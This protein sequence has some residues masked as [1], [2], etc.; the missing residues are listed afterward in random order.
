MAAITTSN[1]TVL[2]AARIGDIGNKYIMV[3]KRLKITLSA[4]GGTAADIP[5]SVLGFTLI[6]GA[7]PA[8]LDVSGTPKS[9]TVGVS[10]NGLELI[11]F[12]ANQATDANRTARANVTGD[13]YVT[14][15]GHA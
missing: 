8:L 13:L 10:T 4:Q 14:V 7:Y 5:A 15:L 1:V 9:A 12:D 2:S 3:M 6:Y 11:T